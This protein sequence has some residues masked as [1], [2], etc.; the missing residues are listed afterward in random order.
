MAALHGHP[1]PPQAPQPPPDR[2]GGLAAAP[3]A[4]TQPRASARTGLTR[5]PRRQAAHLQRARRRPRWVRRC[6]LVVVDVSTSRRGP[7]LRLRNR[8]LACRTVAGGGIGG[9]L[10]VFGGGG[11]EGAPPA[12]PPP[13]RGAPP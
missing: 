8:R 13:P 6:G 9:F 4:R 11:G 5:Q 2:T 3:R 12:P 7:G 10:W 1:Q